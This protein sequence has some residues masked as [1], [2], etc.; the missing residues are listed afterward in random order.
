[1]RINSFPNREGVFFS[2]FT[3]ARKANFSGSLW[4]LRETLSD[5]LRRK[6]APRSLRGVSGLKSGDLE[7][8]THALCNAHHLR[9][10][11]RCIADQEPWAGRMERHLSLLSR[12]K[13]KPI[14]K[15]T[16][17]R[18][19]RVYDVIIARGIAFHEAL[20]AFCKA[21]PKRGRP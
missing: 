7:G 1:M 12:L 17:S 3:Q 4:K 2:G 13:K 9:D 21:A 16:K 5:G 10:L 20:P 19:V 18:F 15:R 8:G 11:Q 14:S 6:P